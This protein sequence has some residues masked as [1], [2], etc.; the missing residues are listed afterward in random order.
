VAERRTVFVLGAGASF[1]V[2]MPLGD[3]LRGQIATH[4][5]FRFKGYQP[6]SGSLVIY[7]AIR[8]SVQSESDP[9][10]ANSAFYAAAARIC[11]AMPQAQSIDSFID[12]H[13]ND[14]QIE[15]CGKWAIVESIL[16][17]EQRSRLCFDPSAGERGIDFGKIEN[18]WF[19]GVWSL[20]VQ[21][22]TIEQLAK[23]L[24]SLTFIVFNY[25][26]CLEQYLYYAIQNYF[27]ASEGRAAELISHLQIF[28]PYGTVGLL[29]WQGGRNVHPYGVNPDPIQLMALAEGVKTFTQR[30]GET[31]G[32]IE[33][34]QKSM[35][36]SDVVA[37]LGFA[38]HPM[39]MQLIRPREFKEHHPE[40][41]RCF[42]TALGFS[43]SNVDEVKNEIGSFFGGPKRSVA[44][45]VRKELT[46][47]ELLGEYSRSLKLS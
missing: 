43:Q 21:D 34:M 35:A 42:G 44:V 32:D 20:L 7:D 45:N 19:R 18:T 27:G 47:K 31:G 5:S 23:R 2:G 6:E 24:G 3:A 1:E 13:R 11:A 40:G 36:E 33:E 15:L 9:R 12:S 17:A 38:F 16:A 30:Q 8:Q 39:N 46:C 10:K 28:H 14:K 29:P 25:D 22:C 4:L 26:R 41:P 37:F